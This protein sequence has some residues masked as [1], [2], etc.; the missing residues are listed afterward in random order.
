M[1]DT[2]DAALRPP[3]AHLV[4][5]P[6]PLFQLFSAEYTI[7][8]TGVHLHPGPGVKVLVAR[9]TLLGISMRETW[10][11]IRGH[12]SC[13]GYMYCYLMETKRIAFTL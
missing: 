1:I 13:A 4:R 6:R 12:L 7:L 10:S 5:L 2:W 11:S 3:G 8:S 9:V